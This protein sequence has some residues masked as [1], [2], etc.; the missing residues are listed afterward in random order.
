MNLEAYKCFYMLLMVHNFTMASFEAI[1]KL[2]ILI[3]QYISENN[4]NTMIKSVN[5][6]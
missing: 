2:I 3:D 5:Y 4:Q 6:L 1:V